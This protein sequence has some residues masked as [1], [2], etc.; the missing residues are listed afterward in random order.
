M[1]EET[2]SCPRDNITP[3]KL[4]MK[5]LPP[6]EVFR[7]GFAV[8]LEWTAHSY[9]FVFDNTSGGLCGMSFAGVFIL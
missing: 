5:I 4:Q 7:E 2:L 3:V 1:S 6:V 8:W 9:D